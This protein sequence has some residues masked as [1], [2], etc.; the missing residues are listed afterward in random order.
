MAP[1]PA[2]ASRSLRFRGHSL[3]SL[4]FRLGI[5]AAI[6]ALLNRWAFNVAIRTIDAAIS[7]KRLEHYTATL[8]IIEILASIRRH[9]VL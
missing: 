1:V 9:S 7:V 6:A 2:R 8:A 3:A 5:M 4:N